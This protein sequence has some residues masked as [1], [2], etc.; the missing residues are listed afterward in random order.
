MIMVLFIHRTVRG[1][2]L[3]SVPFLI[4]ASPASSWGFYGHRQINAM[5]VFAL[6]PPLFGFYKINYDHVVALAVN[7]DKRRY[8]VEGEAE[9][10]YIDLD[11]YGPSPADSVVKIWSEACMKF[12]ED[13]LRAH[14]IVPYKIG[15]VYKSLVKAFMAKDTDRI[16]RLSADIGHYIADAHVPLH[17]TSNYNGQQTGQYGIHGLWESR[18]PE[19]FALDYNNLSDQVTYIHDMNEVAWQTVFGSYDLVDD[20]LR[21]EKE[22]DR[23]TD[24]ALKMEH[25]VRNDRVVRTFSGHYAKAYHTALDGMV[26]KRWRRSIFTVASCWYSAWIDAGQPV[27]APE[28]FRPEASDT[29]YRF[30]SPDPGKHI[31]GHT[32]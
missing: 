3:F 25:E 28:L 12:G 13:E 18:L 8:A 32:D 30:V 19:M 1:L 26:E 9:C 7:P 2:L 14:G 16:I 29:L 4:S 27:L 20:V 15:W 10:H 22:I 23:G 11:H 24:P 21:I 31:P 5:A 6:P 17:C